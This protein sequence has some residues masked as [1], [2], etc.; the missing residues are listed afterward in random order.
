MSKFS[1]PAAVS[2]T[3]PVA[4]CAPVEQLHDLDRQDDTVVQ[5]VQNETGHA[6]NGQEPIARLTELATVMDQD[7]LEKNIGRQVSIHCPLYVSDA[8]MDLPR[9]IKCSLS[10]PTNETRND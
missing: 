4:T 2:E 7:D 8:N 9:L 6:D 10:K 5:E 3:Y 1:Q